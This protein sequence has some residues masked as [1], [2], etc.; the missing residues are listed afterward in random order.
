MISLGIKG[1]QNAP[2]GFN[3]EIVLIGNPSFTEGMIAILNI[4]FAYAGNQAYVT[5]MAEMRDPLV[6][7]LPALC[8][9]QAFAITVYSIVAA[10]LYVFAAQFTTSPALGAAPKL[11][12]KIAYGVVIPCVI[13]GAMVFG[14]SATKYAFVATLRFLGAE[15]SELSNHG[16]GAT[17]RSWIVW[18]VQGVVFWIF[19]F[20]L[21]NSIPVFNSI[22]SIASAL[23]VAL[24]TFGISGAAWLHL[25]K[26]RKL[27]GWKKTS[28]TALNV[29]IILIMLVMNTGGM[30]AAIVELLGIFNDP[31]IAVSGAFSCADNGIF[32]P[33]DPPA[34][35]DVVKRWLCE[36]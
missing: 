19:A 6:D 27:K 18:L 1:P 32:K 4:C 16:K 11:V 30:Y 21:A 24:F 2:K 33:E 7:F 20:I 3:K 12:A 34:G 9:L 15:G 31:N 14:N 29:V 28:L 17:R 35:A 25:N 10:V 8:Y 23:F 26:G 13:G 5:I 22:L 36:I